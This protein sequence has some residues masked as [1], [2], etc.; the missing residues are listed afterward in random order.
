MYTMK[1]WWQINEIYKHYYML[2]IKLSCFNT[3]QVQSHAARYRESA[4]NTVTSHC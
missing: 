3:L 4:P 1:T 2:S